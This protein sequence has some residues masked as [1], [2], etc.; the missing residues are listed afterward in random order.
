MGVDFRDYNNDGWPDIAYTA[1]TA[2]TFPLFRNTGKGRFEDA[3][4]STH[5]SRLTAR[6]AGWSNALVDIDNDGWKDLFTANA[7][8][9]DNIEQFSGDRYKLSNTVF[10]NQRDGT[11]GPA[12]EIGSPQAHRGAVVV[13]L[14]GDGR[15]DIAVTVL[16]QSPELW[17]NNTP[18]P[19]HWLDLK[20]IGVKSNRD[21]IG[22]VVRIGNQMNHQTS[23]VGYAS[24]VLGP[25]HF[26]LGAEP[27]LKLI[28]VEW[29][30]GIKQELRD[31][32]T[33]QVLVVKEGGR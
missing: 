27:V 31:V 11:F 30:S 16:G 8:V 7:H 33:N 21:G 32:R 1:L 3:T 28:A 6:L 4:Y 5:L 23:S 14:D 22:A 13:D 24:S 26:G 19:N 25:M 18:G 15:P 12:N 9:S 20:L 17:R 2:E 29:P 10:L